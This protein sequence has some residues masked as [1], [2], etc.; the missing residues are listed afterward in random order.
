VEHG[1]KREGPPPGTMASDMEFDVIF[2]SKAGVA[3]G[4]FFEGHGKK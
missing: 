2:G 3:D 4:G 1:V